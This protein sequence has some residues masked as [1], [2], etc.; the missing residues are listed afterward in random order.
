MVIVILNL[1]DLLRQGNLWKTLSSPSFKE[2]NFIKFSTLNILV[3]SSII[4]S[5]FREKK[6]QLPGNQGL[7]LYG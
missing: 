6:N 1:R 7:I 5:Q 4:S 3:K 2:R